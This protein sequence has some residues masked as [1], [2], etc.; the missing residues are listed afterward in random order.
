MHPP[1]LGT[2]DQS[3]VPSPSSRQAGDEV[4]VGEARARYFAE[5]GF[6]ADGG[7]SARWVR[8]AKGPIP[9][10][11]PNFAARVRAVQCHDVHHLVTGYATTWTG[12]AE[13]S[14][15]ELASGCRDYWAA[16]M[17]NLGGMMIGLLIAP[18]AVFAACVRGRQTRNVYGSQIDDAFL[19]QP[20][21]ALRGTLL[22]DHPARPASAADVLVF[23]GLTL[24]AVLYNTA[25]VAL[26]AY[27]WWT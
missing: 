4:S 20:L 23:T 12:E 24:L 15:W 1:P 11:F 7:Y 6:A 19:A 17:L 22:L 21:R 16:W 25:G 8:L 10:G 13:I 3:L 27:W 2:S 26:V 9:I 5:N 18:R 14:A